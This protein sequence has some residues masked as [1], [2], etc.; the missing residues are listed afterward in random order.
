MT[1]ML[2]FSWNKRLQT[3]SIWCDTYIWWFV[4]LMYSLKNGVV[5]QQKRGATCHKKQLD[6]EKRQR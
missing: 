1:F 6:A 2:G 5:S 4:D 3:C